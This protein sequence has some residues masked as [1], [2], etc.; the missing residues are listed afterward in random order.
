MN[1]IAKKLLVAVLPLLVCISGCGLLGLR[2]HCDEDLYSPLFVY[3]DSTDKSYSFDYFKLLDPVLPSYVQYNRSYLPNNSFPL[4][5]SV[6]REQIQL[7]KN[8][9]VIDT[10]TVE[11]KI[12]P[13]YFLGD[14]CNDPQ[15][16]GKAIVH[17]CYTTGHTF[18]VTGF[19]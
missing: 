13:I 11:Y 5:V 6:E 4:L 12:E 7:I 10:L 2:S 3:I 16:V 9:I 18:Q 15:L 14:E 8:S 19:H 1:W 17:K